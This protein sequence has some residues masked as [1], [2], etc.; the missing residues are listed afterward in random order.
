MVDPELQ[1]ARE[2]VALEGWLLDQRDWDGWLNLYLPEAEYWVPCWLDEYTLTDD[3]SSQL[4]LIYYSSRAGLEDR[5]FRI[6]TGK[7]LASTPLPRTSHIISIVRAA[8][9]GDDSL[10]VES[11]W[12]T[13]S[14][15]LEVATNFFGSQVHILKKTTS[16]LRIAKRKIIVLNDTIPN[17]LDIY[18]V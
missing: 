3:P 7:S 8:A 11:S 14:Y 5:V 1:A 12:S 4:S 2:L 13:F 6:R 17:V 9:E 18:S 15:K 10:R 16:G